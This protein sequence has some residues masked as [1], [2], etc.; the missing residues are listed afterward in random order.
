[1]TKG[2]L[3]RRAVRDWLPSVTRRYAEWLTTSED[4]KLRSAAEHSASANI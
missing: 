4:S 3:D 2:W 1:M